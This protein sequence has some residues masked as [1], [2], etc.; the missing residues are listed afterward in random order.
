EGHD[1]PLKYPLMYET[2]QLLVISKTDVME[3]FDFDK[4]KVIE[5]A[6]MRNPEIEILFVSAKTGDGVDKVADWII[7]N[8]REWI[9]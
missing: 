8:T 7:K 1:K 3:Y 6:K 5:Y 2:C 9:Q 4:E